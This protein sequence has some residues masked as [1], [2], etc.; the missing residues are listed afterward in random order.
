MNSKFS[1]VGATAQ[2]L[3]Q[4][5]RSVVATA[6]L[7]TAAGVAQ[8]SPVIMPYT[9]QAAFTAAVPGAT[10]EG[11]E[12]V[13]APGLT[14]TTGTFDYGPFSIT[15]EY[16]SDNTGSQAGSWR[17]RPFS[18]LADVIVFDE[19]LRAWGAF[20]DTQVGGDGVGIQLAI[21][22]GL[23]SQVVGSIGAGNDTST[24]QGFLG[25]SS[26]TPFD[27]VRLTS[28]KQGNDTYTL[29]N[30]QY[31]SA[32]VPEPASLV[33]LLAAGLA[34]VAVGRRGARSRS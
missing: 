18:T 9:T 33:L 4:A 8:A 22:F 32:A 7:T 23:G 15:K 19:P 14:G 10:L 17:G 5:V 12:A 16:Q 26:D 21:V 24:N 31:A 6:L 2:G 34:G 20:L 29:D 11:F 1:A 25:F 27:T 13:I 30:M 3:R 28:L